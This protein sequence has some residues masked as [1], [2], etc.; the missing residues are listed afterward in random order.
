MSSVWLSSAK[1]F[2]SNA[3][4]E[5]LRYTLSPPS[6]SIWMAKNPA[7][8]A[9]MLRTAAGPSGTLAGRF[10]GLNQFRSSLLRV[11]VEHAGVV[12][13]EERILDSRESRAFAALDDDDVLRLVC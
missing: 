1:P 4:G 10:D 6:V 13:I 8:T 3:C 11:A 12:E 5:T 7:P 9:T 2:S